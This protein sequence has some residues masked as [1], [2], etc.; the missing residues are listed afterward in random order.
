MPR[1]LEASSMKIGAHRSPKPSC[2]RTDPCDA[3]YL[4]RPWRLISVPDRCA[5]EPQHVQLDL[6]SFVFSP[7]NC[8]VLPHGFIPHHTQTTSLEPSA[9]VHLSLPTRNRGSVSPLQPG[10][11][12]NGVFVDAQGFCAEN[13]RIGERQSP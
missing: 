5:A 11:I 13:C 3:G 6:S 1:Y 8:G 7:R 10:R 9:I 4:E 12:G 2:R